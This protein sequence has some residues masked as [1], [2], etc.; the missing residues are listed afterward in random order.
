MEGKK[1]RIPMIDLPVP[2]E[3]IIKEVDAVIITHTLDDHWDE[4]A[5]KN[6]PKY[7]PI[8]VQIVADKK[9]SSISRIF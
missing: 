8:F 9:I 7:I 5:A 1:A 4:F 6:I 2:V 3:E